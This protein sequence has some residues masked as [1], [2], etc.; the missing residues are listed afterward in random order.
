MR[1]FLN[2]WGKCIIV[3]FYLSHCY[4]SCNTLLCAVFVCQRLNQFH[5]IELSICQLKI[6]CPSVS[7]FVCCWFVCFRMFN[8][9]FFCLFSLVRDFLR[10]L[11]C[12]IISACLSVCLSV[13][14]FVCLSLSLVCY[15][16][17]SFGPFPIMYWPW[18]QI[19]ENLQ[20]CLAGLRG[21]DR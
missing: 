12:V 1:E 10:S 13:L 14:V 11:F 6:F 9:S 7:L 18:E 16:L 2:T 21:V 8:C 3:F 5:G 15:L 20:L 17:H 19:G 4:C